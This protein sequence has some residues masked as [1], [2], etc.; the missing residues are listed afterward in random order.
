MAHELLP[1]N[2]LEQR[3]L[4]GGGTGSNLDPF[5]QEEYRTMLAQGTWEGGFV[6]GDVQD[7]TSVSMQYIPSSSSSGEE[8]LLSGQNGG[9]FYS[10][11][12]NHQM[13]TMSLEGD[14]SENYSELPSGHWDGSGFMT[15][16]G[17]LDIS[18]YWDGS[19][20][21]TESG[22]WDGSGWIDPAE[23]SG[24]WAWDVDMPEITI[25]PGGGNSGGGNFGDGF[26]DITGGFFGDGG[27]NGGNN[28]NS[29]NYGGNNS[30]NHGGNIP[31]SGNH[32]GG[33]L[34]GDNIRDGVTISSSLGEISGKSEAELVQ[35][36]RDNVKSQNPL[37]SEQIRVLDNLAIRID[38]SIDTPHYDA[39]DNVMYINDPQNLGSSV[40]HE[41][42]HAFQDQMLDSLDNASS[43]SNGEFQAYMIED[44]IQSQYMLDPDRAYNGVTPEGQ[45]LLE[46]WVRSFVDSSIGGEITV[47]IKGF[48][49][50][51]IRPVYDAFREGA[52][53]IA[54]SIEDD[55]A[56][57]ERYEKYAQ[58]PDPDFA[59][60]WREVLEFAGFKIK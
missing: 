16:S 35:E 9:E 37:T 26:N 22:Y 42:L 1:V 34:F 8:E 51:N 54:D 2:R 27:N 57:K 25:T 23:M 58:D 43:H 48:D 38:E 12:D 30:G 15:D 53:V 5:S 20:F 39:T 28:N 52:Q 50:E 41:L 13:M 45:K 19:G 32:K 4:M 33:D 14:D 44:V 47:D 21:M 10:L 46:N 11:F 55:D 40:E 6:A 59:W 7:P 3:S 36:F 49:D 60:H 29:G 56:W 24:N 17:Y 18:G 31:G